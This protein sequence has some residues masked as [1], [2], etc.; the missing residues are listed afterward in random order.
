MAVILKYKGKFILDCSNIS[1]RGLY[2]S[3][4]DYIDIN[5]IELNDNLAELINELES[6]C[7]GIGFDLA[8]YIYTKE[9]LIEFSHLIRNAIDYLYQE[10]PH[11]NEDYRSLYEEFYNYLL[12][13]QKIFQQYKTEN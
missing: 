10:I 13:A 5:N 6:G 3:L 4:I 1:Y 7:R 8:D 2:N 12:D 9:D 11:L